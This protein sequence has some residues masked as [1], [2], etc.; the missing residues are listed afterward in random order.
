MKTRLL[1]R[2]ARPGLPFTLALSAALACSAGP[3]IALDKCGP[4][5]RHGFGGRQTC[6]SIITPASLTASELGLIFSLAGVQRAKHT[7]SNNVGT[8]DTGGAN[9]PI[10]TPQPSPVS[11]APVSGTDLQEWRLCRVRRSGGLVLQAMR[12]RWRPLHPR[13]R[14]NE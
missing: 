1:P 5:Q 3:G 9:L 14:R 11:V 13:L 2:T 12:K 4:T 10:R 7:V 8:F 6:P